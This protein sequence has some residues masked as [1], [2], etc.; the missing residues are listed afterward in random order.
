MADG[1]GLG[2]GFCPGA[3][4]PKKQ[5]QAIKMQKNDFLIRF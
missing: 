3:S 1:L 5:K 2:D 4:P